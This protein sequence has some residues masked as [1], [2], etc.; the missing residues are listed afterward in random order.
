MALVVRDEQRE[1]RTYPNQNALVSVPILEC[2]DNFLLVPG[3][4]PSLYCSRCTAMGHS[5]LHDCQ[6]IAILSEF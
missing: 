2:W 3:V 1:Q 6:E 4:T 5:S